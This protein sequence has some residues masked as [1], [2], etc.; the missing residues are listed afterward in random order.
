MDA[1]ED[2][3]FSGTHGGEVLSLAAARATLDELAKPGVYDQLFERGD[4]LR[5]G[6]QA[7]IDSSGTGAVVRVSGE[8]PRTVVSVDEPQPSEA[9]LLA[10]S[11]VQQ[12]LIKRG[13]LFNGSNFICLAHS[14]EDIATTI[15]AWDAA[16]ARLADGLGRRLEDLL[17]GEPL[18]SAFRPV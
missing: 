13:V 17:E 15:E 9:G 3:F 1:L 16:L 10:K 14:E 7:A 8:A 6:I 11:L 12:E 5:A 18:Q 4:R 2:V